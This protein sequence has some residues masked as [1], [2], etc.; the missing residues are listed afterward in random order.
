MFLLISLSTF[1]RFA[2]LSLLGIILAGSFPA[3]R[4]SRTHVPN[5]L[6]NRFPDIERSPDYNRNVPQ[7]A[8][9][10]LGDLT[11]IEL[12]KNDQVLRI[13]CADGNA[14]RIQWFRPDVLRVWLGRAGNFTDDVGIV[15]GQP[16]RTL[17]PVLT[18]DRSGRYYDFSPSAEKR[19]VML[20]INGSPLRLS[21][22]RTSPDLTKQELIWR[23]TVPL[24][25]NSTSTFQTLVSTSATA[26]E[27]IIS[28]QEDFFGG[29]MQNGRWRHGGSRVRVSADGNWDEGGNPNASPF[30]LS[31][32][33]YAV[34]RNTWSPGFYDFA[35]NS[36]S[37]SAHNESRF[38]GF[39]FFAPDERQFRP[40][41]ESYTWLVGRPF[42]PPV[43]A[44]GLGDSDCYH[45]ERHGWDTEVAISIA[46][47]YRA[48]DI[49]GA[50]ILPNDG[51][52]CGYGQGSAPKF[53][54][55][56]TVLADVGKQLKKRG[57]EVGLWSS[58]GL[59][60]I[61]EE[62]REGGM[63]VG[64]TDVGWIG[65]GYKYAFDSCR[66][67]ADGIEENSP[68]GARRFLWTV[69]GWAPTHRLG[70][71]W[72][73][74]D[75]GTWDYVRWQIPTF[76]GCGF[77]GQAH[78]SGDIDGIFGGGAEIYVRD[79]QMKSMMTVLMVMSGWATNPDKQ[80]WT[81]GEPYTAINRLYLKRKLRLT[82]YTY[83]LAREAYD[84]GFPVVRA[85]ALEFP[86]DDAALF[87]SYYRIIG[88]LTAGDRNRSQT[89][90]GRCRCTSIEEV[91]PVPHCFSFPTAET[92]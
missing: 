12:D 3:R 45:N 8:P 67:V 5:R 16:E 6:I 57:F 25:W 71:M 63:R 19:S 41:L 50:W 92:S 62:V 15:L 22:Y 2:W 30:W 9:Q 74:D 46:E 91:F 28:P 11:S 73:G 77:S 82:P 44:L 84:T 75:Y 24:S 65:N 79:L 89:A 86:H 53:P 54:N 80:P 60:H 70:V 10:S 72:T 35:A 1:R 49:P 68:E 48:L 13:K 85:T 4:P 56:I 29:G 33:G 52:G 38:D 90:T 43:Y 14:L 87:G 23:E 26:S 69:E 78:V 40:L 76:I 59:P 20:R 42:L 34:Y 88:G 83:T 36:T 64:K 37:T 21:S 51:Y 17:Q 81:Y 55:N 58:T 39:Y 61:G 31:S 32:R 18:S 7:Q 47:R 66:L 27:E